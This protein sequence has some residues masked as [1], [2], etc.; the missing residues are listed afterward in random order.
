MCCAA[1]PPGESQA[2]QDPEAD[3]EALRRG[4]LDE[5]VAAIEGWLELNARERACSCSRA[6]A[7][8]G[9]LLHPDVLLSL[10]VGPW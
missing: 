6:W 1:M 3:G 8:T 9:P 10:V 7:T 2:G 4:L 5:G